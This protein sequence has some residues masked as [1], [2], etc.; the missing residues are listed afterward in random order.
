MLIDILKYT[1]PAI[2]NFL[3]GLKEQQLQYKIC[4]D[5]IDL[6]N[7]EKELLS[8]SILEKYVERSMFLSGM[9]KE[10]KVPDSEYILLHRNILD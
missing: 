1:P 6:K 2:K 8:Q 4:K 9:L 7:R 3:A 5:F 10:N